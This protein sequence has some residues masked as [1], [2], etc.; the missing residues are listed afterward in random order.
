MASNAISPKAIITIISFVISIACCV[1]L[2]AKNINWSPLVFVP[3]SGRSWGRL[4]GLGLS[5]GHKVQRGYHRLGYRVGP[6]PLD[7][8][9]IFRVTA[10]HALFIEIFARVRT[11]EFDRATYTYP[12]LRCVA[13]AH[14][15]KYSV[16]RPLLSLIVYEI[17]LITA[18]K[19]ISK[20]EC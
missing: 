2:K 10:R 9:R 8:A 16:S 19:K 7:R 5:E 14:A 13:I 1:E 12:M 3:V 18:G 15:V 6:T 20:S 11:W 4:C 17:S